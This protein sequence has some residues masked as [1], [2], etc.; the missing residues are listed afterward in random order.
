MGW[1][2]DGMSWDRY[3]RLTQYERFLFHDE[4]TELITRVDDDGHP[5]ERP[6]RMR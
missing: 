6:K 5:P 1:H 4:L 2:L 3:L